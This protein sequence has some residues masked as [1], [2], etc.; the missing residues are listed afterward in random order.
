M[1]LNGS[2]RRMKKFT[3]LKISVL[4]PMARAMVRVTTAANE[5][6]LTSARRP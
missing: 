6:S 4:T 1:S 3:K 5:G 2:G